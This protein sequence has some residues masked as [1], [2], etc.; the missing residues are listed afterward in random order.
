MHYIYFLGHLS[1]FFLQSVTGD[2][3][4]KNFG[5]DAWR[6]YISQGPA[7][8][9]P[10]VWDLDNGQYEV[11]FLAMEPGNYSAQIMLDFTLCDGSRES[12]IYWFIK[13]LGD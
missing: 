9:A 13:G 5:G 11:V 3:V 1:R 8:L 10:Q 7:S 6:V 2:G 12:P 4:I